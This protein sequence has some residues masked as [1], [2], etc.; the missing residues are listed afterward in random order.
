MISVKNKIISLSTAIALLTMTSGLPF[1]AADALAKPGTKKNSINL[2]PTVTSVSVVAGQLVA[3]GTA[4]ANI[5]RC[6]LT[7]CRST[8]VWRQIKLEPAFARS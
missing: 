2:V 6:R 4:T 5:T 8:S 7:M 3:A 1:G